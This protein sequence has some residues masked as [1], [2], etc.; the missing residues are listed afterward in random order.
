M[1]SN[2]T[3]NPHWYTWSKVFIIYCD[4]ASFSG[5][6]EEPLSVDETLL[7]FRGSRNLP[8]LFNML[9]GLPFGLPGVTDFIFAG[10]SA[11]GLTVYLHADQ[12]RSMMP[13][14]VKKF[15][16]IPVS[17]WFMDVSNLQG[18][19]VFL[20]EMKGVY[21]MQNCVVREDCKKKY[22]D[23]PHLCLFARYVFDFVQTPVFIENS[24]Y[25]AFQISWILTKGLPDQPKWMAC[26]YNVTLCTPAQVRVLNE[27]WRPEFERSIFM[28]KKIHDHSTGL[29][30]EPVPSHSG[31]LIKLWDSIKVDG[32]T[33][34]DAWYLWYEDKV[35]KS[36]YIGC[37]LYDQ[38]P[39]QC[40]V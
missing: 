37:H 40:G 11:G 9:K 3:L 29:F 13:P 35:E 32:V 33:I 25:D 21:H 7:Y 15:K 16:A 28:T 12:V 23:A 6:R 22:A 17:G 36:R 18:T 14:S 5:N 19:P 38:P 26:A 34:R 2:P 31:A 8:A 30:L 27:K 4:G 24:A 10:N 20:D 1:S 39:Y